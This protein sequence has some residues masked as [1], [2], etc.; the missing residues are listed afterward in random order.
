ML[1]AG[2]ARQEQAVVEHDGIAPI[3]YVERDDVAVGGLEHQKARALVFGLDCR[4]AGNRTAQGLAEQVAHTLNA[5]GAGH[6]AYH[7]LHGAGLNGDGCLAQIADNL[8]A[9]HVHFA[10]EVSVHGGS[11]VDGKVAFPFDGFEGAELLEYGYVIVVGEIGNLE[12]NSPPID[13][14]VG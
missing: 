11:F 2:I 12:H 7:P 9:T 13:V 14:G 8:A 10:G 4:F 5:G 6:V 1:E 3:G